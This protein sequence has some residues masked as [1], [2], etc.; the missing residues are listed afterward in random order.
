MSNFTTKNYALDLSKKTISRGEIHD[1]DVIT[2]SIESIL[3]TGYRERV[4]EPSYGSFLPNVIFERLTPSEADKLLNEVI[5]LITKYEDRITVVNNLCKIK[6]SL[7]NHFL[8]LT[9]VYVINE[10]GNREEFNK[11]IVF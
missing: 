3:M 11:R 7:T 4:F 9:I 1:K 2:Q 5:K 10:N 8:E 6:V